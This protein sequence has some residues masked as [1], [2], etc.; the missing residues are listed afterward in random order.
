MIRA[1]LFDYGGTLVKEKQRWDEIR[2]A[3]DRRVFRT[4]RAAGLRTTFRKFEQANTEVF[5]KFRAIEAA[6]GRDIPDKTKYLELV[7]RLF[8]DLSAPRRESLAHEATEAFWSE[9]S[10]NFAI[11]RD[12]KPSL[13]KLKE[14][15]ILMGVVSNHHNSEALIDHLSAL[16]ILDFFQP[17]VASCEAGWRKPDPRIFRLCLSRMGVSPEEAIFVGDLLDF[18]ILG[19]KGVGMHSVLIPDRVT[20]YRNVES[21]VKPDFVVRKLTEVPDIVAKLNR[22]RHARRGTK[23]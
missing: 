11:R 15:G 20:G 23:R 19:A 7:D 14:M 12:T 18:D 13:S 22:D 4:L 10:K 2:K 8:G 21:V 16:G 5:E 17:V 6:E 9:G 1:V 3:S